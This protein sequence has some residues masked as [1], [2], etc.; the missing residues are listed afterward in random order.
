[1]IFVLRDKTE[2]FIHFEPDSEP[3][4]YT[5]DRDLSQYEI[6]AEDLNIIRNENNFSTAVVKV[7][8]RHRTEF[9]AINSFVQTLI[10]LMVALVTFFFDLDDFSDRIMV[11]SVLLLVMATINSSIQEVRNVNVFEGHRQR[12]IR[13]FPSPHRASPAHLTSSLST[14]GFFSASS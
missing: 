4:S 10:V 11:N 8:L 5:G 12:K 1:M 3:I 7:V 2:D 13:H 14:F 6:E 9:H